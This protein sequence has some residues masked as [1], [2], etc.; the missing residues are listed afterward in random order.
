[1]VGAAGLAELIPAEQKGMVQEDVTQGM[2]QEDV[3]Q[4]GVVT[5]GSWVP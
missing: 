3:T 1:M 5:L 2:V 4:R